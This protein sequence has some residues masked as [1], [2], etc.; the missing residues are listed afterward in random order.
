MVLGPQGPGR[1][2][3]C[4]NYIKKT[5][6]KRSLFVLSRND[7]L[8]QAPAFAYL[9]DGAARHLVHAGLLLPR[10]MGIHI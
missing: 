1:V 9:G 5:S 10:V 8:D 3:R 4:Q 2:G 6:C 7:L